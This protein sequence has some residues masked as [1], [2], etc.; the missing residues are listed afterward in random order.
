MAFRI[1]TVALLLAIAMP[2]LTLSAS[3]ASAVGARIDD[4]GA[5]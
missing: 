2:L 4:N 1:L 5:P 3:P